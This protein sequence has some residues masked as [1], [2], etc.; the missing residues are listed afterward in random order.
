VLKNKKRRNKSTHNNNNKSSSALSLRSSSTNQPT[1]AKQQAKISLSHTDQATSPVKVLVDVPSLLPLPSVQPASATSFAVEAGAE[2]L[3]SPFALIDRPLGACVEVPQRWLWPGRIPLG[4]ITLVDGDLGCGKSLLTQQIAAHVSAGTPLPDGSQTIKGGVVM[5]A[6]YEDAHKTMM[7]RFKAN[8]ADLNNIYAIS[9]VHDHDAEGMPLSDSYHPFTLP[10]DLGVLRETMQKANARL[11]II[12]PFLA[13]LPTRTRFYQSEL[14]RILLQLHQ[15]MIEMDATCLLIRQCPA[16]GGEARPSALERS[17]HF[18]NI[19]AS[20]LLLARDPM[21][22]EHFL[23]THAA[24]RMQ[25]LAPTISFSIAS[26]AE[27]PHLPHITCEGPH[28]L[29]SN[30]LLT[31]R[32]AALHSILLGQRICNLLATTSEPVS[33]DT[34]RVHFPRSTSSQ[35]QRTLRRLVQ[36]GALIRAARGLY[37]NVA[38]KTTLNQ[39]NTL[40]A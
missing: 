38:I 20:R 30:D 23:L 1:H 18:A 6:P 26:S 29:Q 10:D 4:T 15:L 22:P 39:H 12:D 34:I 19:A 24:C 9:F 27:T 31:Q 40:S 35:L 37:T 32:P 7:A 28:S 21:E 25:A 17:M 11:V 16:K 8:G 36:E 14:Q 33:V 5:I 3:T 13:V 2:P